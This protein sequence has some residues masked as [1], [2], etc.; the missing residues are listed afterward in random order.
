MTA[1][2]SGNR[3]CRPWFV[4]YAAEFLSD[5]GD[6]FPVLHQVTIRLREHPEFQE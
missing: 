1:D 2:G 6:R 4:Q 5:N 3:G